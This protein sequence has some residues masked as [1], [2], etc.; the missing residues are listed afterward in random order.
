MIRV[1]LANIYNSRHRVR[2][3]LKQPS[4]ENSK[5]YTTINMKILWFM[6][7]QWSDSYEFVKN[8][9]F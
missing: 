1:S 5:S 2:D 6:G 4:K 8:N 9:E 7:R 3:S